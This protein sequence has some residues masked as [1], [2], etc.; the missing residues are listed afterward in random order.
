MNIE[1]GFYTELEFSDHVHKCCVGGVPVVIGRLTQESNLGPVVYAAALN[2][3]D[4]R[5]WKCGFGA[6]EAEAVASL[7]SKMH[8][9]RYH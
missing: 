8:L 4:L 7:F 6:R 3:W 5:H 2:E 1:P 9:S